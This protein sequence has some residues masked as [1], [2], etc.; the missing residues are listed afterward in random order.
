MSLV[1]SQTAI[2]YI[3]DQMIDFRT[4][5][6]DI[7]DNTLVILTGDNSA[8]AFP[9]HGVASGEVSGSNGP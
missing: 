1:R 3:I 9:V 4:V 7:E 2:S 8:G 5:C 6:A